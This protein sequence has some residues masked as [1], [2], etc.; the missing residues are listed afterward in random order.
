M[1]A[2]RGPPDPTNSEKSR[3]TLVQNGDSHTMRYMGAAYGAAPEG[4]MVKA[5]SGYHNAK[6]VL[7]PAVLAEVQ[8]HVVGHLWV[9]PA[10]STADALRQR[11][12]HL[13]RAGVSTA[14]IAAVVQV[15]ARRVQQII[16]EAKTEGAHAE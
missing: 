12:M 15:S 11:I 1:L 5:R 10:T 14:D 4:D 9:P 8:R 2:E 7:P 16:R 3:H 13:H 6:H